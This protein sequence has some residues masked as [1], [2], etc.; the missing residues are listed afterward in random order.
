MCV[1]IFVPMLLLKSPG[2]ASHCVHLHQPLSERAS[3]G[4]REQP[5]SAADGGRRRCGRNAGLCGRGEP[6]PGETDPM[7]SKHSPVRTLLQFL[8]SCFQS[9]TATREFHITQ[10]SS[11]SPHWCLC[12][13]INPAK[14]EGESTH[15]CYRTLPGSTETRAGHSTCS[16]SYIWVF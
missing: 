14:E 8:L 9:D 7:T 3:V 2:V 11:S 16:L 12:K 4:L 6:Q 5:P 10:I 15:S 1:L 13:C